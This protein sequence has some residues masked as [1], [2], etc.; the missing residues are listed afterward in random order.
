MSGWLDFMYVIKSA[1]NDCAFEAVGEDAMSDRTIIAPRGLWVA[2]NDSDAMIVAMDVGGFH[3]A[4]E[5]GLYEFTGDRPELDEWVAKHYPQISYFW[6]DRCCVGFTDA[7]AK[8]SFEAQLG[9]R[10]I[11]ATPVSNSI[12]KGR[13]PDAVPGNH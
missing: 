5:D 2:I 8:T 7:T 6:I 13:M 3:A 11:A 12:E 10:V 4:G 9:K 1:P